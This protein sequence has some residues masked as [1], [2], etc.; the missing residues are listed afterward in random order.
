[1]SQ[2]VI[3]IF[4]NASQAQEA[5][6]QLVSNGFSQDSIDVSAQN[7]TGTTQADN[8]SRVE[9][10]FDNLFDNRD[11]A[12][13]YSQMARR[14]SMVTVHAKTTMEAQRAS[15]ILDH[16][17]AVDVNERA[18][19]FGSTGR[20]GT[21]DASSASV[22]VIEEQLQVGKREVETGGVRV[23]SRIIERP[24][25]ESLRLRV[26]HVHVERI[27]VNRV[28]TDADVNAFQ[29][30]TI[31]VT[32]QAEVPVV[33]KAARVV[34][35]ISLEKEVEEREETIRDTVRSTDVEVENVTGDNFTTG[36]TAGG[37]AAGGQTLGGLANE[38]DRDESAF[39]TSAN[40][41]W[42]STL[43]RMKEVEDDY[44]VSDE[45]PDVR[46]WDVVGRNGEK[47]GEVDE[48][49]VDTQALKVRYLDVDMDDS[50]LDMDDEEQHFLLPIGAAN[51]DYDNKNVMVAN[52]DAASVSQLPAYRGDTITREYEHSVLAALSPG[53]TASVNENEFY[54]H[55]NFNS[56]RFYGSRPSQR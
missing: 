13:S 8:D 22:P 21:S 37:I 27:P 35:E 4:D 53:Y 50:L 24:V 36:T 32:E 52:L 18:Q 19:Q 6:S 41:G 31:E 55:D 3:G 12:S 42:T 14:G 33:N 17:G 5:V 48:L 15:Q 7:A 16:Y 47:I 39:L 28:V 56:D 44:K 45:D 43:K 1:M 30:R 40:Q 9:R 49:I 26:E 29:E 54:D 25:E 46:G 34:E 38:S 23:R 10:F 2:T 11:E 20:M 51:L